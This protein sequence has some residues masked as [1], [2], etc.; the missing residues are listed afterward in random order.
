[1]R[2]CAYFALASL[3]VA[4]VA[5][6]KEALH[7]KIRSREAPIHRIVVLPV[8]VDISK[9]GVKG[10]EGQGKEEEFSA[11][12]FTSAVSA[13]L[14]AV[15]M[16][17]QTPY[18]EESLRDNND[19]K[20]A[21]ADVQTK[22]DQIA[23]QLFKREKD[24]EKGRF[25]LGDTVAVLNAKGD[26]DAFVF[27]RAAGTK[28]TKGKAFMTGGVLGMALSGAIVFRSHIAVVDAKSGDVLFMSDFLTRGVPKDSSLEKSFR[29]L[30]AGK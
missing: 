11:T 26:A 2:A 13:A 6:C 1:M 18:S 9:Q 24:V 23:P 22:F 27:V 21:I 4:G 7:P 15:G 8:K 30:V 3:F 12:E 28:Q 14:N 20:Y 10:A 29:K 25:S 5:L 17:V 16:Q 19:L